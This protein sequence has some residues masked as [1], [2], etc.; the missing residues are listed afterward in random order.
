MVVLGWS[1]RRAGG[2][3]RVGIRDPERDDR[4][5]AVLEITEGAVATPDGRRA[6][7]ASSPAVPGAPPAGGGR[8]AARRGGGGGRRRAAGGAG[9]P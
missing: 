9:G 8:G 7:A 1:V 2:P 4:P 6:V 3:G 5:C